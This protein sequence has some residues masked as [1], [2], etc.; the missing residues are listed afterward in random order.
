[1]ANLATLVFA[2]SSSDAKTTSLDAVRRTLETAGV[3]ARRDTFLTKD[4]ADIAPEAENKQTLE[5]ASK[6]A[7]GGLRVLTI[8]LGPKK[9]EVKVAKGNSSWT[10]NPDVTQTLVSFRNDLA[11]KNLIT[12]ADQFWKKEGPILDE[13]DFSVEQALEQGV[14]RIG[15]AATTSSQTIVVAKGVKREDLKSLEVDVSQ[16]L[17]QLRAKLEADKFMATADKFVG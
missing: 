7:A 8:R 11:A 12:A 14:L 13:G 1:M 3:M 5:A 17:A 15:P 16:N 6:E 10:L 9:G 2:P 4:L